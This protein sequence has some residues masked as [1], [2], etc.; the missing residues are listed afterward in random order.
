MPFTTISRFSRSGLNEKTFKAIV[1]ITDITPFNKHK[2]INKSKYKLICVLLL[3]GFIP[4]L[5]RRNRPIR[6]I[7]EPSTAFFIYYVFP[8]HSRHPLRNFPFWVLFKHYSSTDEFAVLLF[9]RFQKYHFLRTLFVA[10]WL[11]TS[12]F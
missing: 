1:E 12:F 4:V 5:Q 3:F 11:S 9:W 8:P 2:S 7:S 10:L 6:S